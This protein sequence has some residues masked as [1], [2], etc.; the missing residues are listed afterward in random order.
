MRRM[1]CAAQDMYNTFKAQYHTIYTV[2]IRADRR[3]A[4]AAAGLPVP[5]IKSILFNI[6][7]TA[8]FLHGS[9]G[10]FSGRN[11]YDRSDRLLRV[12]QDIF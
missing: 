6:F 11:E 9:I 12:R 8:C 1:A 10:D 4:P 5:S 7:R 2:K 3:S